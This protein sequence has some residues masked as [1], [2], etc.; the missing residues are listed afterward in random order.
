MPWFKY[1][2]VIAVCDSEHDV[3]ELIARKALFRKEVSIYLT[4][5]FENIFVVFKK[6]ISDVR[7]LE[8]WIVF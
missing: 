1:Q 4:R 5:S 7:R 2:T 8:N 6:E 3:E